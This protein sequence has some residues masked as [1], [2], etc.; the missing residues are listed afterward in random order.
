MS[1]LTGRPASDS[2]QSGLAVRVSTASDRPAWDRFVNAHPYGSV[3]H[4]YAWQDVLRDALGH[5]PHFLVAERSGELV[6]VMPL[7][8]M[9]SFFFGHTLSS[10]PFATW[11]GPLGSERE[12]VVALEHHAVDLARAFRVDTLELRYRERSDVDRPVK[13]IYETFSK[14]IEPDA[15]ANMKAIRSKQRNVIRKGMKAGLTGAE[16]DFE[17]FFRIYSESV[18]NLGTPV[19]SS[20]LFRAIREAFP[21]NTEYFGVFD[22]G[23]ALSAAMLFYFRDTVCPYYWGGLYAARR[24]AANDFLAWAIINRA[25]ARGCSLFDF[26]RSKKDTGAHQW[27][28]N[29]GFEPA[30]LFYEY[31]LIRANSMPEVNPNNPR[32]SL[33]IE[34]WKRLPV[35]L[36]R[37]LG[38]RISGTLG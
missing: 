14:P 23:R 8:E 2:P 3:F 29:L 13:L 16:T 12:V 24:L 10:M 22:D 38:P 7:V 35:P 17:T 19:F 6:G 18:R 31:E 25:A 27:K 15:D 34:L 36:S 26:G 1:R 21:E 9:R 33:F 32:Y 5:R 30:Q 37:L 28:L 11:S 20:R 4:L